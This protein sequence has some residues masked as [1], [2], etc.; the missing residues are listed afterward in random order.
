MKGAEHEFLSGIPSVAKLQKGSKCFF[1]APADQVLV[2]RY[3]IY[4]LRGRDAARRKSAHDVQKI[5]MTS[6]EMSD[7]RQDPHQVRSLNAESS[8][9]YFDILGRVTYW[10]FY[11]DPPISKAAQATRRPARDYT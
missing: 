8:I 3:A 2:T 10:L 9:V 1:L 6:R 4:N 7:W 11:S 5:K